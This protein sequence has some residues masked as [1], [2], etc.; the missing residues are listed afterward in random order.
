MTENRT[1]QLAGPSPHHQEGAP[2]GKS[3]NVDPE[4]LTALELAIIAG[5]LGDPGV[6]YA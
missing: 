5:D 6:G 4:N 1:G 3:L 2:A